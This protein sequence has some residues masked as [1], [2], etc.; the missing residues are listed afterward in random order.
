MSVVDHLPTGGLRRTGVDRETAAGWLL[1]LP[2]VLLIAGTLLWPFANAVWL[3]FRNLD[4]GAFVGLEHYEWL[5]SQGNFWTIVSHS[6][7][8]T[9]VNLALQGLFGVGIALLLN[10][11][12]TGRD[13]IRTVMLIPFVLPM[14]ITAI[15]WRWLF[16]GSWGPI[17]VWLRN[18]GLLQDKV[19]PF[20]DPSMA[21]GAVTLV[22]VWR[23]TP[24]V[25][26][27]VFAV[28]QTIPR[29][30]Y[31]AAR[32]E[33]A[34][35][36]QE[37]YHVTYPHLQRALSVLGLI[38]V[39]IIF[40]IFDMIWLLTQGGPGEATTTLPVFIYVTAFKNYSIARGNAISVVLL[41]FLLVFV[42]AFFWHHDILE[43][44]PS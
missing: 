6:I 33:G 11:Q 14:A 7:T 27:I 13:T 15:L 5:V 24:L 40:N 2:A 18:A 39:L 25:A 42:V 16:N 29:E 26:L 10:R 3:S 20:T 36:I 28:L 32:I 4:T 8:W 23:W 22:N 31:E 43:R 1:V 41:L 17:N 12:F 38:G 37:F 19:L 34:G 44:D 9:V 30:E 35:V 21:L